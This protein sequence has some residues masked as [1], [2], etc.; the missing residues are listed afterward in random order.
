MIRYAKRMKQPANKFESHIVCVGLLSCRWPQTLYRFDRWIRIASCSFTS[1]HC[2]ASGKEVYKAKPI[3]V[4]EIRQLT[5]WWHAASSMSFETLVTLF[6]VHCWIFVSASEV[7]WGGCLFAYS[8]YILIKPLRFMNI[9]RCLRGAFNTNAYGGWF[10]DYLNDQSRY[11]C[12][13]RCWY[14]SWF[15]LHF[16]I[17]CGCSPDTFKLNCRNPNVSAHL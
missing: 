2:V 13:L 12:D 8:I 9:P 7:L 5:N 14:E 16:K 6:I 15:V 11:L 10:T 3:T 1:G 17:Y 4:S